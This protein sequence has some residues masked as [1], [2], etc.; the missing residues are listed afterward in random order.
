[1]PVLTVLVGEVNFRHFLYQTFKGKKFFQSQQNAELTSVDIL[2]IKEF[3]M[4]KARVFC[5][6][7]VGGW[8]R[9][10]VTDKGT[11]LFSVGQRKPL[12]MI[13]VYWACEVLVV[14]IFRKVQTGQKILTWKVIPLGNNYKN[15]NLTFQSTLE[16]WLFR[17]R[18]CKINYKGKMDIIDYMKFYVSAYETQN[19]S[20]T[21]ENLLLTF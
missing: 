19:L 13:N 5:R 17:V 3:P 15:S 4:S 12:N 14:F 9:K 21:G 11:L 2:L 18:S 16:T 8:I 7:G 1:M 10:A 6:K 20:D